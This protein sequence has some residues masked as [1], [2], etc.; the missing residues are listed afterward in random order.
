MTYYDDKKDSV[1][2]FASVIFVAAVQVF[3][4]KSGQTVPI[5]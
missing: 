1:F 3:D 4:S 2:C 5:I